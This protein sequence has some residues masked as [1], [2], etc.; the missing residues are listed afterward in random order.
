M[1]SQLGDRRRGTASKVSEVGFEAKEVCLWISTE[2][3]RDDT[4]LL[5][6]ARLAELTPF[7]CDLCTQSAL[8]MTNTSSLDSCPLMSSTLIV[9]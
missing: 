7:N 3:L 9:P 4:T 1:K 6:A 2:L 8:R 5:R